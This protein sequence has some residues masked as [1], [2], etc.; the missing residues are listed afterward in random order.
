MRLALAVLSLVLLIV[1]G[2]VIYGQFQS[3][4]QD[5]QKQYLN[6]ALAMAKTPAEKASLE[7]REPKLEQTIVESFKDA[8]GGTIVERC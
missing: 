4:W 7:G 3:H 2:V 6:Q 1:A 8:H 5:S